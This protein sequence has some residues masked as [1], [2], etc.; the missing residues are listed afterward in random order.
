VAYLIDTWQVQTRELQALGR[1]Q[2]MAEECERLLLNYAD[3]VSGD[4]DD[5]Y[6][7][8][9]AAWQL[10]PKPLLA[11]KKLATWREQ[12]ARRRNRPRSWILKDTALFAIAN[13]MVSNKPQLAGIEEVSDN[14]V[15]HEGD[16]VLALVAEAASATEADCP[17][18][19]AAP[20]TNG[21]KNLLKKMQ[22]KVD[23]KATELGIPPELLGRK[24][25]LMPLLYALIALPPGE[26]LPYNSIPAELLGWRRDL[27]L[28]DLLSVAAA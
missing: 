10:R 2:W 14:F 24:R 7:N 1:A 12:R 20:L 17:P 23:S 15:R 11:L 18:R 19:L 4:F 28:D 21:Q 16:A 5:Y 26:T 3:E 8:F 13:N 25:V 9:K 27:I 22:Q 6:L